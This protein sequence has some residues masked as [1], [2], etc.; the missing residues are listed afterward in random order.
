MGRDWGDL[1][2]G[3]AGMLAQRQLT[4]LGVPRGFVR[5][6][7]RAERWARRTASVISTTTGPL[8]D[9]QRLWLAVLHAG[10]TALIGA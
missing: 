1:A 2:A 7:L 9:E 4:S 10:P 3:Q 6:Q 8:S 5:S